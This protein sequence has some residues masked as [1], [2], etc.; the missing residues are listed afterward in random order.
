MARTVILRLGDIVRFYDERRASLSR[1]QC[2][3]Q[4][5]EFPYYGPQGIAARIGS[6]AYE[7]EY[8]LLADAPPRNPL[9]AAAF[10]VSGRFSASTR[11]HVLACVEEVE[12]RFLCRCLNALPRAALFRSQR[13]EDL[14]SIEIALLPLEDQRQILA[15]LA[16]IEMKTALLRD[17]NRVLNAMAQSLFDH[18]FVFG[19]GKPR[20]LG[21]FAVFRAAGLDA[22]P[23]P[24]AGP[25]AVL[26]AA[27][28]AGPGSDT[29]FR[30]LLLSPREGL[31]PLFAR[32]LVKNPE[33]LAYAES[34]LEHRGGGRRL[35]AER[36]MAFELSGPSGDR[37]AGRVFDGASFP[38]GAYPEFAAFALNAEKKLAANN[39]ELKLLADIEQSLFPS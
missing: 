5:G 37:A 4:P 1:R 33:F 39:A 16:D 18:C 29:A 35:N 21:D 17:Q 22:A 25:G 3:Q 19:G 38:A 36:L 11:V 12:P 28:G 26:D 27:S 6:F 23:G 34:C 32:L 9:S 30:G 8:L 2:E 20:P 24:G 15:A 10:A 31:P 13:P 7:G 14:D